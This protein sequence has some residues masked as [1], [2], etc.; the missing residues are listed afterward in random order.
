MVLKERYEIGFSLLCFGLSRITANPQILL[1][2]TSV[3]VNWSVLRFINKNSKDVTYSVFLYITLNFFFSYMNIMRQAVAIGF[4]LLAFENLKNKKYIKYFLEVGIATCFHSSAILALVLIILKKFKYKKKYNK[5]LIPTFIIVFIFG[6]RILN[7]LGSFSPRLL[8]YIGGEYDVSNYLGSIIIATIPLIM[9]YFGNNI[10]KNKDKDEIKEIDF[11]RKIMIVNI[12]F[13]VLSIR[14]ILFNRFTAYFAVFQLAWIPNMLRIM[15]K[16]RVEFKMLFSIAF[17]IYW[18][19]IMIYRP[20]W[21][22]A[23]P[24]EMI[25]F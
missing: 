13:A 14:V 18:M 16:N 1:I 10:L 5:F 17:I 22:G 6:R 8:E 3:F 2:V 24:Y 11:L 4:V 9:L 19:V 25:Q 20:E 21:Y 12:I 23:I 15:K 7:I